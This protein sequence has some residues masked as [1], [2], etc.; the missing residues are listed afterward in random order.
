MAEFKEK[1]GEG[2]G[3]AKLRDDDHV[4]HQLKETGTVI[5]SLRR[6]RVHNNSF[7]HFTIR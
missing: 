2:P 5:Q 7:H 1:A 6:C 3:L 4:I